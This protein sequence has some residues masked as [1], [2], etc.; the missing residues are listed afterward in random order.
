MQIRTFCKCILIMSL[1]FVVGCV[2]NG[3]RKVSTDY[4]E[5]STNPPGGLEPSEVPM[6]VSIGFD[7]NE[8]VDGLKWINEFTRDIQ[9]HDGTPIS[10]SFFNNGKYATN[11]APEW[12]KLYDAGHEIGNHSFNHPH[13]T[14]TKWDE[15]PATFK[16]IMSEDQWVEEIKK[17]DDVLVESGIPQLDIYGFR[18]P[19][20]EYS[21]EALSATYDAGFL[22]DC[23]IE[24]GYQHGMEA[25]D[26]VWPY[27]LDNGSPGNETVSSWLDT[28][29]PIGSYPGLWELP[30]YILML[31]PDEL[32]EHYGFEPGLRTRVNDAKPYIED[33]EWKMTG[34]DYNL[35]YTDSETDMMSANEF[36]ATLKYNL[37]LRLEGNRAPF[38]LGAHIDIYTS[39]DRRGAIEDFINY[40][41][42]KPEVQVV[43]FKKILDWVKNPSA[44]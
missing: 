24:E 42:T 12:K 7:D 26:L 30:V 27:T 14:V 31:P 13:G 4:R 18:N 17:T 43:S 8:Y 32:A 2:T 39:E 16:V 5:A 28:R 6:F 10:L 37:D 38:M 41:L 19:F 33:S 21:D 20:L 25:T 11:A 15:S 3:G 22:Y 36:L 34:F 44:I 35:W 1:F 23:S 9:N 29:E 40:A